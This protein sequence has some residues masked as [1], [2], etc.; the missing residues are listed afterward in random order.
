M[1]FKLILSKIDM[2]QLTVG[3]FILVFTCLYELNELIVGKKGDPG[4]SKKY[5]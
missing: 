5:V 1:D 4:K 3:Y 2:N